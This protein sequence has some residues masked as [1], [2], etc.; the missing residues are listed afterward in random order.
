METIVK[1]N[2]SQAARKITIKN[3][4]RSKIYKILQELGIVDASNKP[5]QNYIDAGYLDYGLPTIRTSNFRIKVPV[6]LVVG[7]NG[8]NFLRD[9][10][11]DY[12]LQNSYPI[13][14]KRK[15]NRMETDGDTITFRN[16]FEE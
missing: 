9:V 12:L 14:Y 6:T 15:S 7:D 11:E 5:I 3:I 2:L 4:G 8:L 10:I 1:Y 16:A 13:I